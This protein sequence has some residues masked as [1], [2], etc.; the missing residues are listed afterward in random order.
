MSG[1]IGLR[2]ATAAVLV[3]LALGAQQITPR[4]ANAAA[5]AGV[6]SL[7]DWQFPDGCNQ[8]GG[9]SSVADQEICQQMEDTLFTLDNHLN[10]I[11]DLAANFPT[12]QNG[13]VKTVN[14]NLVV[15]YKLKPNL[16][17]SDGT[18]FTPDDLTFNTQLQI[19]IGATFGLD[20]I[21]SMKTV[22]STTWEVTYKGYYAPFIAFGNPSG[23]LFPKE[24]LA[25]KYGSTDLTAIGN[26]LGTDL[27]N[28]PSDVFVGP[29]QIQSW[30]NGQSIV[31]KP[32]PLYNALPPDA[33][34]PLPA[35]IKFVN[36]A[37]DGAS[38]AAALQSPN[39][40]VDKAEDFQLSDLPSLYASKYKVHPD[41]ALTYEHLELNQA[42][43]L[44]DIRLREALQLAIN[45]KAL[46]SALFPATKN[47]NDF[48]L[49]TVIP[50]FS[51]WVNKSL[52]LSA[53]DPAQARALIRAAGYSDQYNGSGKHL[54]LRFATTRSST[55]QKDFQILTRYWAN[56]GVHVTPNFASGSPSANEG[57]FSP[58]TL[59]GILSHRHFDI[60]LFAF[61][62][63]PD[64][65][66]EEE[67]F[68]PSLIP[69]P[70][71][72]AAGDQNYAGIAD[73]DQ[74]NLLVQARHSTDVNQRHAIINQ[75]QALLNQR[76]YW[77]MLYN[78]TNITVDNGTIGNYTP[79]PSNQ[80]NSWNSFQWYKV[81]A[82]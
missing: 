23:Q 12:T 42:G 30:T 25:K 76:V 27:Y 67:T 13:E 2:L 59:N 31:L 39:A 41:P 53:Y 21:S 4:H 24:Y 61:S 81:G 10:Y 26:K 73:Q 70:A 72:H 49:T 20:Q 62:I 80:G 16:K 11:P 5:A 45:K 38:L 14:G 34:H 1:K 28:T 58:Y 79:N 77:I 69:T 36:I 57:L 65:Q 40:G 15:D 74:Y 6:V 55:R 9:A 54:L 32:D 46:F 64:P 82:S 29:Y 18:A 35:Q 43:P 71:K 47:V 78:R 19:S 37:S 17:W 68:S 56:I 60:A 22:N 7:T 51:P 48:M 66:Q 52:K 33:H 44:K 75:W 63:A 50:S 8:D 3:G